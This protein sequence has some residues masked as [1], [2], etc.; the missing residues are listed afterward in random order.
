MGHHASKRGGNRGRTILNC[1]LLP[2]TIMPPALSRSQAGTQGTSRGDGGDLVRMLFD[3]LT[4][5]HDE[6]GTRAA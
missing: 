5:G 4:P 1:A 2:L 6:F 3:N